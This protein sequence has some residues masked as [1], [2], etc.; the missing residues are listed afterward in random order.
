MSSLVPVDPAN[1]AFFNTLVSTYET[2]P[3][4][5]SARA[6]TRAIFQQLPI[7]DSA[8]KPNVRADGSVTGADTSVDP[9]DDDTYTTVAGEVNVT[10]PIFRG[11]R[12]VSDINVAQSTIRGALASL[13]HV[14]KTFF[15]MRSRLMPMLFVIKV[16]L[17]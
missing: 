16:R 9:G 5:I 10:Q 8:W 6:E 17:N 11:G 12:T 2:N 3:E 13:D 4:L 14:N 7:A 15:L 1:Q